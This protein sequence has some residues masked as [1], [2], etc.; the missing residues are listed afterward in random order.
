M[1]GI[2]GL[3]NLDGGRVE[4]RLL[5]SMADAIHYRGPDDEGYVLIN[6]AASRYQAYSGP[7][8]PE[9]VRSAHPSLDAA[10]D[11]A[12]SIGLAHRR[13]SIIDLSADGHQPLFSQ[14]G[15]CCVVFNGEIY[16]YIELRAEL[17]QR[18]VRFR[19]QSDTEVLIQAYQMWGT[20]CFPRFNGFWALALYDFRKR[21]LILSRDRLGKKPL[22]W[23]RAGS[24]VYFASEIKSLLQV[25]EVARARKVNEEAVWHWCV[26]GR[27][28]LNNATLFNG[29]ESL[30]A[31]CWTVVDK[32]F[33]R[34]IQTFWEVPRERMR[35]ADISVPEAARRVREAL[36]DA[37]RI[38]LRADVPLAIELS[39]GMDSSTVLALAA[40]HYPGRLTAY[41]VKYPDAYWDEEP[42][43][44]LV[45]NRYNVDHRVLEPELGGFWRQLMDF[46][47]LQEEPYHSPN[48]HVSQVIWS[49]MR[50]D[51]TKVTLTGA[52]GDELFAGY[53]DYHWK[54]Q[55][56]NLARGRWG[57]LL[58]NARHWTD[59]PRGL[60]GLARE[61]VAA[62][63][64]RPLVRGIKETFPALDNQY[65]RGIA[66]PRKLYHELMLSAWLREEVVN[67]R[68]PY[69]L[70]S[71]E[72]NY[73]GIP[74]E[75]RSPFLD[76]RVVE[77]ATRLP[78]TYLVRHGWHKWI[79]RKAMED[80]LP[81]DVVWRRV[82]MG[83][84]YPYDRF[85]AES[86][87]VIDLIL[88]EARNPYIDIDRNERLRTNWNTLSFILW[89]ELFFNDNKSLFQK[90]EEMSAAIERPLATNY[91]P[92]FRKKS[93]RTVPARR[94]LDE[95]TFMPEVE[96]STP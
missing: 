2:A 57:H 61:L 68:I 96:G 46:T 15:S 67:T 54:V 23:T 3:I 66:T 42:F 6:Q 63:H 44:R 93:G 80:S 16:N 17:E 13:F 62:L 48:M 31:A 51:G 94:D 82:K 28:D 14:D 9:S 1:C 74:F 69:W 38:R 7:A 70:R 33:P 75:A 53:A 20:D 35:E 91:V 55:I 43:A 84:P 25:P 24:R 71:G 77:L 87:S 18:G 65:I 19:S 37:V 41:T 89:Y 92:E 86:R 58:A 12:A 36:D 56:E 73:M 22:Y 5:K 79:L 29:I 60:I 47:Y 4:P 10:G 21:Q 88:A 76:Y 45:A 8:S 34:R 50:A 72:K 39:G 95:P 52:A 83:F 49:R 64:L 59:R 26:D 11:F 32:D 40:R 27:R 81:A 85:F 78:T 30:P 90:I